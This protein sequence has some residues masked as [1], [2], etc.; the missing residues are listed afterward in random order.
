MLNMLEKQGG[1][2]KGARDHARWALHASPKPLVQPQLRGSSLTLG[3]PS[4]P[5]LP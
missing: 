1:M 3:A 4:L 2:M 5:I